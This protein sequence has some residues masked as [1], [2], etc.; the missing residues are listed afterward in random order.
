MKADSS[1][2][3]QKIFSPEGY[4]P[5][6][7][8]FTKKV[9]NKAGSLGKRYWY[10]AW[11][12]YPWEPQKIGF[13]THSKQ[14]QVS[15]KDRIERLTGTECPSVIIGRN[16]FDEFLESYEK[17]LGQYDLHYDPYYKKILEYF[18]TLELIDFKETDTYIDIGSWL[19]PFPDLIRKRVRKVYS[20]DMTYRPGFYQNQIGCNAAHIPL[21]DKSVDK[22]TLHCTF[23]HF[24]RDNDT[25]FIIEAQRLLRPGG[26]CFIIPLYLDSDFTNLTDPSLFSL[27]RIKFD[28]GA[29]ICRR[30]GF[31]N[32]FG[33][34]YSPEELM[35]RVISAAKDMRAT[36]YWIQETSW[37]PITQY[38][39]FALM[40][41]PE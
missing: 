23:E 34:I 5:Y 17:I 12:T 10:Y 19:S 35:R 2:I 40:L 22:M 30:F 4:C 13:T 38:M 24:E 21:P 28:Q 6:S 27:E 14:E 7:V 1:Y 29:A 26:K 16:R 31:L 8:W 20:Q 41:E 15:V 37:L 18:L 3:S 39:S 11:K 25:L 36:I 9:I 32:R 33:R